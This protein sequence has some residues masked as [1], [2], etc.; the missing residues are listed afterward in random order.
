MSDPIETLRSLEV[1]EPA[2][3]VRD[4]EI[5]R[6]VL[7]GLAASPVPERRVWPWFAIWGALAAAAAIV[8]WFQFGRTRADADV[9]VVR[10]ALDAPV[11]THVQV[12]VVGAE[13][14]ELRTADGSEVIAAPATQLARGNADGSRWEL[15][16]GRVALAVTKR[17]PGTTFEVVTDEAT[18]TVVGTHFTVE[19]T[20][21]D[22]RATTRV[23]VQEGVVRV[24]PV[25]GEVVTLTAGQAWP[26]T[27]T[28]GSASDAR[29]SDGSG[30]STAAAVGDAGGAASA[31]A[32]AAGGT[33]AGAKVTTAGTK[34][35]TAAFDPRGIRAAIRAGKIASAR[36]L[37]DESRK[38][39]PT[40][41]RALAEL[42][43]LAAE[44]DLAE[45]K[46]KSAIDKYLAVV[47][48]YPTTPQAEQALFAAAQLAIDQPAAGY[49]PA[50]LLRDYVDTYPRGQF[51]KDAAR[52][53][54]TLD[55]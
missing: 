17:A 20:V 37:I 28:A 33:T 32:V 45:R 42:G 44:A 49:R 38:A 14:A 48:D 30:V 51:A 39:F 10:G 5:R 47:R 29:G 26:R 31:G 11:A 35:T 23:A 36:G 40:S 27:E 6:A 16:H 22:G 18:V 2:G 12:S 8:L 24:A 54:S 9:V 52:L 4:R 7:E 19:R 34:V 13:P 15:A 55:K 50:A 1:A 53:L 46:T 21:V 41:V 25:H 3:D 43:I